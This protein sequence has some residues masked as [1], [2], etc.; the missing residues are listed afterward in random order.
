MR[1]ALFAASGVLLATAAL[2]AHLIAS[3]IDALDYDPWED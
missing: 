3:L 2:A 1:A